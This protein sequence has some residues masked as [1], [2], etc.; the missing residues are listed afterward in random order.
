MLVSLTQDAEALLAPVR[1]VVEDAI[2]ALPWS[3]PVR[4]AV[5]E[6]GGFFALRDDTVVLSHHLLAGDHPDELP[7]AALDRRRR[8][9]GSVLEGVALRGLP[10]DHAPDVPAWVRAGLCLHVADAALPVLQLARPARVSARRH[11]HPGR[12]PRSGEAVFAALSQAGT[13]PLVWGRD[14]L[15]DGRVAMKD[16]VAAA[17][18]V[19]ETPSALGIDGIAP[20]A[21]V[22]VPV[23]LEPW[24]WVR[25][26]VPEHPRGGKVSV[27]G[28]GGVAPAWAPGGAVLHAVAAAGRDGAQLVPELGG[29]VGTWEVRTAGGFGD[30][31]G[32]RGVR[33]RFLGSGKVEVVLADAYVGSVR[34][35]EAAEQVGSSG[36]ATGRW[37]VAG[38]RLLALGDIVTHGITVH[39]RGDDP[40]AVPAPGGGIGS[41]VEA[42]AQSTWRWQQEGDR[43]HMTGRLFD[44]EIEIRLASV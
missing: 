2:E 27:L 19:F 41:W 1:A 25:L 5:G 30:V 33:F 34:E 39:G 17:R 32:A 13:D 6:V 37:R 8:A 44:R 9:A 4:V 24:Q 38:P 42:M 11:G 29:P 28:T 26:E 15:A 10:E 21:A 35:L 14:R 31:V 40:F 20:V 7:E 12:D 22:D 36:M 23:R 43:L 16:Y 18:C 3:A